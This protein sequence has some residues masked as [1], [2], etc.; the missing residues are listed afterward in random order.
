MSGLKTAHIPFLSPLF[1]PGRRPVLHGKLNFST[2]NHAKKPPLW[3]ASSFL[4]ERL[5]FE[6]RVPLGTQHF[7]CCT[8]DHSDISPENE[9]IIPNRPLDCNVFI[10][11]RLNNPPY[12]WYNNF[13][14]RMK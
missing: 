12:L 3:T 6:P 11:P 8:I 9:V 2:R 10:L 7:E 14:L 5:G 4:A 1:S 13:L